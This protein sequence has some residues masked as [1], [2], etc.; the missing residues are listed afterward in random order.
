MN[1]HFEIETSAYP[2]GYMRAGG[3]HKVFNMQNLKPLHSHA[4][5]KDDAVRIA[6]DTNNKI[7]AKKLTLNDVSTDVPEYVE[8][9]VSKL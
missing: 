8:L 5:S 9:Q 6:A 4:I 2:I 1:G 7:R 3:D